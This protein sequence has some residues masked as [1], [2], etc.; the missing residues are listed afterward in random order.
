MGVYMRFH[1]GWKEIFSFRC[2]ILTVYMIQPEIKLIAGFISLRSFWQKW[3]FIS[4]GKISCKHYPKWINVKGNICACVYSIKTKMIGF[5]WMGYFFFR[6]T[7]ETKFHFISPAMESNVKIIFVMVDWN[8][9]SGRFHFGS[10]VS[11]LL[12]KN[13]LSAT[14][15]LKQ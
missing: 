1:F 4:G 14:E 9:I 5:Y 7:P 3:N 15:L 11:T 8:F 12:W 10:H 13:Q 2:L 6:T